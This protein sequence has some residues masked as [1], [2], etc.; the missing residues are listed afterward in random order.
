M[1]ER[2]DYSVSF[3]GYWSVEKCQFPSNQLGF[4]PRYEKKFLG[5]KLSATIFKYSQKF[6]NCVECGEKQF[7]SF[8]AFK[9][10]KVKTHNTTDHAF[11]ELFPNLEDSESDSDEDKWT[12]HKCQVCEDCFLTEETYLCHMMIHQERAK[13]YLQLSEQNSISIANEMKSFKKDYKPNSDKEDEVSD[14][15]KSQENVQSLRNEQ[16][17]SIDQDTVNVR[18]K[19]KRNIRKRVNKIQNETK[20]QNGAKVNSDPAQAT[21][22]HVHTDD[23]VVNSENLDH[24]EDALEVNKEKISIHY[25]SSLSPEYH[26]SKYQEESLN[27]E[28]TNDPQ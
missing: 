19:K 26:H 23:Q 20:D 6:R 4:D 21:K 9:R 8:S 2:K 18:R 27:L 11:E 25:S 24:V 17:I 13:T 1:V 12:F 3:S 5:S 22:P 16:D 15:D 28:C 10:H 7:G 14:D